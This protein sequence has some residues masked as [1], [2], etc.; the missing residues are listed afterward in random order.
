TLEPQSFDE[1]VPS[2]IPLYP[3]GN[4]IA[5]PWGDRDATFVGAWLGDTLTLALG[6]NAETGAW[7]AYLPAAPQASTLTSF[8]QFGVY[9][10]VMTEGVD[11]AL[12]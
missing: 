7:D 3:G 5:F 8:E 6:W 9:W 11:L 1:P 2:A 10:I 4:L 12:N